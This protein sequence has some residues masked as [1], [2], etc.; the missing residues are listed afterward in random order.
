MR[1][2]EGAAGRLGICP[3]LWHVVVGHPTESVTGPVSQGTR[4]T[5]RILHSPLMGCG[6][7]GPVTVGPG[8]PLLEACG[9]HRIRVASC[10][11]AS[12]YFNKKSRHDVGDQVKGMGVSNDD[13]RD[14]IPSEVTPSIGEFSIRG[15]GASATA[16][17]HGRSRSSEGEH[18][19]GHAAPVAGPPESLS[20]GTVGIPVSRWSERRIRSGTDPVNVKSG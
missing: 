1:L 17:C 13:I 6:I 8:S 11:D 9:G 2:S 19:P 20:R 12:S 16:T 7:P 14:P 5:M 3:D 10:P 4:R 15:G 18:R